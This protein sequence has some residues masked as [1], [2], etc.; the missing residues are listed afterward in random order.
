M[1]DLNHC[2][3]NAEATKLLWVKFIVGANGRVHKVKCKIC[4]K[5]KGH[6]KLLVSKLN[7]CGGI[8]GKEKQLLQFLMWWQW[9]SINFQKQLNMCS[10]KAYMCRRVEIMWCNK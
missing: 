8:L 1:Y 9:G 7:F 6:N 4:R 10:M 3:Q 2:F 5:I